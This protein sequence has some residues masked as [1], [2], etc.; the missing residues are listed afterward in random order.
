MDTNAWNS[1]PML[2]WRLK[3]TTVYVCF[4]IASQSESQF[5]QDVGV[6]GMLIQVPHDWFYS[7]HNMTDDPHS[8]VKPAK[9]WKLV[10]SPVLFLE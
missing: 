4:L 3:A 7:G 9:W 5:P 8:G 6:H 10:L 1:E 2:E